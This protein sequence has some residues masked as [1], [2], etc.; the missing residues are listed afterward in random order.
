MQYRVFFCLGGAQ[1][2]YVRSGGILRYYIGSDLSPFEVAAK[3]GNLKIL[4]LLCSHDQPEELIRRAAKFSIDENFN[5]EFLTLLACYLNYGSP[6]G[7]FVLSHGFKPLEKC[8][9]EFRALVDSLPDRWSGSERD[10][11][12]ACQ[13]A[14]ISIRLAT[15][16]GISV[17]ETR[18]YAEGLA[19]MKSGEDVM[20]VNDFRSLDDKYLSSILPNL[21]VLH[22]FEDQDIESVERLLLELGESVGLS[23]N[24]SALGSLLEKRVETHMDLSSP[25]F[26][27]RFGMSRFQRPGMGSG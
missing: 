10:V 19:I 3:A 24:L 4:R 17:D 20:N 5:N 16:A 9:A 21:R 11:V 2:N 12:V 23:G 6:I 1:V 13:R 18:H 25:V 14:G 15:P 7:I 8:K 27:R 22:G 26:P